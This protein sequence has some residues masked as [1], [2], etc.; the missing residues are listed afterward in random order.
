ML[1]YEKGLK[2]MEV[3]ETP[4]EACPHNFPQVL[5]QLSLIFFFFF[6]LADPT[7]STAW[8]SSKISPTSSSRTLCDT[9]S[10]TFEHQPNAALTWPGWWRSSPKSSFWKTQKK[11]SQPTL[12]SSSVSLSSCYPWTC[13]AHTWRTRCPSENSFETHAPPPID[14]SPMTSLATCTIMST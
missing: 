1:S 7:C 11:A 3:V 14:I 5:R 10:P 2:C 4:R 6:L 12:F 9:S 13:R 8:C